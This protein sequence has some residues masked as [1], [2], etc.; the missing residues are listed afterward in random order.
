MNIDSSLCTYFLEIDEVSFCQFF[1][2]GFS[3]VPILEV[4]FV[5]QEGNDDPV[6]PLVLDVVYPLLDALE[7]GAIGD[8]IDDDG[9]GSISDIVGYECL[10]PLL[11]SSVPQLQADSLVLEEDVLGDEVDA[12]GGSL[13]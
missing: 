6:S 9:Y 2:L 8:I 13:S 3:N 7:G 11:A 5:G 10:E 4:D 12:D 1:A